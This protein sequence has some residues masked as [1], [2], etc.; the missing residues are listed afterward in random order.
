MSGHQRRGQ[1]IA[2]VILNS[3]ALQSGDC[4]KR[5]MIPAS[6][7]RKRGCG[8]ELLSG[9][10]SQT[11]TEQRPESIVEARNKRFEVGFYGGESIA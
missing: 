2:D 7:D 4:Q 8:L 3:L 11:E 1:R 6:K 9:P 10:V 5:P